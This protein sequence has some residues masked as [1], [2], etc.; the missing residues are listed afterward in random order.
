MAHTALGWLAIALVTTTAT[1]D[2]RAQDDLRDTVTLRN[3]NVVRGRILE[4]YAPD[5][6]LVVQGGRRIRVPRKEVASTET[7]RDRL[8]E[9]LKRRATAPD[10]ATWQWLAVEWAVNREL[11]AMAVLQAHTVLAIDPDHAN[12]RAF[13]GHV[14]SGNA[15]RMQRKGVWYGEAQLETFHSEWG[16]P[17]V[18]ESEHFR[19]RTNAG[20]RR[21]VDALFDLEALYV[22][23]FDEFGAALRPREVL[24][25]M[26][27][28]VWSQIDKFPGWTEMR[29]PYFIPAPYDDTGYT[30]FEPGNERPKDLFGIGLQHILYRSLA[31]DTDAGS[32]KNRRCAWL[33]LGLA[34]WVDAV[35]VGPPGRAVAGPPPPFSSESA[36]LVEEQKRYELKHLLHRHVRDSFYAAVSTATPIDWAYAH[37][38]TTFLMEDSATRALLME[39]LRQ[40]LRETKGDSSSLF[41]KVMQRRI[42]TFERPFAEWLVQWRTTKR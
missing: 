21:A 19:I 3:G 2:V 42:E 41:D 28:F 39:Y 22:W 6:L 20:T 15:W 40:A 27:V 37:A 25:P 24:Q 9:F 11:R 31:Y 7:L 34:Q 29:I 14:R 1:H 38:F 26:D 35:F 33:E 16:H 18:L 32:R 12:A 4:P 13:L 5:E 36:R 30:F 17:L 8:H 10:N 23:W